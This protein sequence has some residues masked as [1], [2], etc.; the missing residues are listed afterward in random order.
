MF[1]IVMFY[2]VETLY[3]SLFDLK[4]VK[5]Y[6]LKIFFD[7][8]SHLRSLYSDSCRQ[9]SLSKFKSPQVVFSLKLNQSWKLVSVKYEAFL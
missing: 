5:S 2:K 4:R 3:D 9:K 7:L 8:C 6:R 1:L